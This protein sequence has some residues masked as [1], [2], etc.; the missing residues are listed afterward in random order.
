MTASVELSPPPTKMNST[1]PAVPRY[2]VR[3]V[4]GFTQELA[5]PQL[6]SAPWKKTVVSEVTVYFAPERSVI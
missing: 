2:S 6:D 1:F 4:P 3:V 5:L